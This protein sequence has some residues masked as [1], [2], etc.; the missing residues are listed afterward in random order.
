M[1]SVD[2]PVLGTPAGSDLPTSV[3]TAARRI[4]DG[5]LTAEKTVVVVSEVLAGL[6]TH[7]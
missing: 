2:T 7:G 3:R 5:S 1:S 4:R 6:N